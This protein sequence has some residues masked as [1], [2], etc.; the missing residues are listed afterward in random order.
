MLTRIS[1]FAAFANLGYIKV[2]I[3]IIM[4]IIKFSMHKKKRPSYCYL[5]HFAGINNKHDIVDGNTGLSNVSGQD[6]SFTQQE[7]RLCILH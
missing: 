1:A 7:L 4:I 5:L 3:I 6:L 2:I